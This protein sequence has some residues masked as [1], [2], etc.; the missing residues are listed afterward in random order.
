MPGKLFIGWLF[1][2]QSYFPRLMGLKKQYYYLQTLAIIIHSKY[3]PD[4][5]WVKAHT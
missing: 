1:I 2:I 3:F 4:S 5:D